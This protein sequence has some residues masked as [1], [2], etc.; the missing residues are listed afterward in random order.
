MTHQTITQINPATQAGPRTL[1]CICLAP[2]TFGA[3]PARVA[4]C[5]DHTA[6]LTAVAA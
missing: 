1:C 2:A 3:M 6:T 4:V 5:D